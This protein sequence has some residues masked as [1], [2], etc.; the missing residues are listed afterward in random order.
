MLSC[1]QLCEE[2]LAVVPLDLQ[3]QRCRARRSLWVEQLHLDQGE[4]ELLL[5]RP[6]DRLTASSSDIQ[7]RRRLPPVR[8]RERFVGSERAKGDQRNHDTDDG[9]DYDVTRPIYGQ[10]NAC[11]AEDENGDPGNDLRYGTGASGRDERIGDAEESHGKE[12]H[13]LRR[14]REPL[15]VPK[16]LDLEWSGPRDD[17][18]HR[19]GD[20]THHEDRAEED[21][22]MAEQLEEQQSDQRRPSENSNGPVRPDG[23][24]IP[25][26]IG[27]P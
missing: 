5:E 19:V 18:R 14:M 17:V 7:V 9:A 13:R 26:H 2:V 8:D 22:E 21:E 6:L 23:V 24:E 20:E 12:G 15:P 4:T 27:E 3:P 1:V 16:D 25:H 11:E 10:V